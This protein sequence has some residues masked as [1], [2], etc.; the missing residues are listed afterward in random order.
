MPSWSPD[1]A[2]IAFT[3]NRTG[4]FEVF[5]VPSTGGEPRNI[6]R[7]PGTD[8]G[9]ISPAWAPNGSAIL[10]PSEAS[11]PFWT[12]PYILQGFGAAGLLVAAAVLAGVLTFARRHAPLPFGTYTVLVAVPLAMAT[13]LGDQ[14]RFIPGLIA[15]GLL[16]DV[17]ARVWPAGRS[18]LGD[19][20]L[21]FAVPAMVFA[22]YF[23]TVAVTEGLGWSIHMWL[24]AIVTAGIIGLFFDELVHGPATG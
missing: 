22:L 9:W 15:A 7:N 19:A 10:Y 2:S 12:E 11:R 16:A 3:S 24:G 23:G 8:D 4:D 20:A 17:A 21:A 1:G 5:V 6:S 14:Y 18:R 13:V